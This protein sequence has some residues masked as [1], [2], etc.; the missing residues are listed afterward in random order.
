ME[1]YIIVERFGVEL[2]TVL[3]NPNHNGLV[4]IMRQFLSAVVA[5]HDL[6]IMHGDLKPQSVLVSFD[7]GDIQVKL[8]DLA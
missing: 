5:L 7:K 3:K 1:S 4:T 2:T 8:C 6:N